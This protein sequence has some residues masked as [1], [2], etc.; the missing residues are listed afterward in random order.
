[1]VFDILE[2]SIDM[3]VIKEELG[4]ILILKL[5]SFYSIEDYGFFWEMAVEEND[6]FINVLTFES[7]IIDCRKLK[8]LD[9]TAGEI[10]ILQNKFEEKTGGQFIYCG[11]DNKLYKAFTFFAR[12]LAG[13]EEPNIVNYDTI[14]QALSSLRKND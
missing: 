11:L 7:I 2:R 13:I 14:D 10:F 6:E 1:V 3:T 8:G 9:Q 12:K 5:G 4:N